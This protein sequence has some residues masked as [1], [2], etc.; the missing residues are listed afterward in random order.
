MLYR[1]Q[2]GTP[3]GGAALL[4]LA[5]DAIQRSAQTAGVKMPGNCDK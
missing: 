5:T 4:A 3:F 2:F 1:H